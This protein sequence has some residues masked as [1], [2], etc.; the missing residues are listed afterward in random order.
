MFKEPNCKSPLDSTHFGAGSRISIG[1]KEHYLVI[2]AGGG[3]AL[4]NMTDFV[5][6]EIVDVD[7]ANWLTESEARELVSNSIN[8]AAFSD[9]VLSP[10]GW[11]S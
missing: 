5:V 1:K 4:V 11:K 2:D 9:C 6:S 3:V 7:D 10:M 8:S